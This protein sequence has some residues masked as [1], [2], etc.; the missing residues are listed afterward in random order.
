VIVFH[1]TERQRW[2]EARRAG[3]YDGST[4]DATLAEVGF[5]HCSFAQQVERVTDYLYDAEFTHELV[6][7]EID[8]DRLDAEV[9]VENLDGGEELFPHIYGA[10][11][12]DAVVAVR[13]M[14]RSLRGW[15]VG[16]EIAP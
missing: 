15:S 7:L 1:V 5:I 12:L 4:R 14:A 10:V 2:Q 8:T 9:R 3:S 13:Q 6:V 16:G 11:P